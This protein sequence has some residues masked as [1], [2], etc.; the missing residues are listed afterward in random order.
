L[1]CRNRFEFAG[2]RTLSLDILGSSVKEKEAGS[3]SIGNARESR[4]AV[5]D[6]SG[7]C[8]RAIPTIA[9]LDAMANATGRK[10][11]LDR[12]DL[13]TPAELSDE[14]V[15]EVMD[16]SFLSSAQKA[17]YC[18][19]LTPLREQQAIEKPPSKPNSSWKDYTA[20]ATSAILGLVSV[21]ATSVFQS[22]TVLKAPHLDTD[23]MSSQLLL[24]LG[25]SSSILIVVL[26]YLWI[27][28]KLEVRYLDRSMQV[29]ARHINE[30]TK[31][32]GDAIRR[33][34]Q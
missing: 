29:A 24:A 1:V 30:S 17:E 11:G 18:S 23:G 19:K 9:V 31:K 34:S 13:F 7:H 25:V 5:C 6:S 4:S 16:S 8:G 3:P 20:I 27:S 22:T 28:S 2:G 14:L 10:Y 15:K 33:K 26:L 12:N 21:F 32:L